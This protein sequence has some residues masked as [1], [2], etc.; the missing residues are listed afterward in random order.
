[1]TKHIDK[2][3]VGLV[4]Y[5]STD[6]NGAFRNT[7]LLGAVHKQSQFALGGLVGYNFGPVIAQVY[8]TRDISQSNYTGYDTRFWTRVIVPLGNPDAPAPRKPLVTK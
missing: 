8:L 4:G 2:W 5:G 1:M 3:E 6:L 7:D